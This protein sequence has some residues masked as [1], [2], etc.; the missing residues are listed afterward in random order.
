MWFALT[1]SNSACDSFIEAVCMTRFWQWTFAAASIY[2]SMINRLKYLKIPSSFQINVGVTKQTFS[3]C[4][5]GVGGTYLQKLSILEVQ[6]RHN[7][8]M[9]Q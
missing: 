1:F 3:K 5:P 4:V 7:D 9:T 6:G 8:V 2:F